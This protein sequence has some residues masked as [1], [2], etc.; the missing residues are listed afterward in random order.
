MRTYKYLIVT[1][2]MGLSFTSC[3]EF[4]DPD[5]TDRLSE[6]LFWQNEESTDLYLNSFYPYLSSYGNFGTSQ[7]NNTQLNRDIEGRRDPKD[8][9]PKQSDFYP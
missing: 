7:F 4:L 5:P 3:N 8:H 9:M 6:K 1:I 2:I